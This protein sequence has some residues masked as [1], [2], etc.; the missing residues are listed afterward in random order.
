LVRP[1]N[2]TSANCKI[3]GLTE[4]VISKL[5]ELWISKLASLKSTEADAVTL[6]E[7]AENEEEGEVVIAESE[8]SKSKKSSFQMKLKVLLY[9]VTNLDQ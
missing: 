8:A 5:Q 4:D 9:R 1:L 6:E 3:P 7:G 2:L